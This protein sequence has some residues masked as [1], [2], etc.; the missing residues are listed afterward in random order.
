[1]TTTLDQAF[2]AFVAGVEELG[3]TARDFARLMGYAS[4][5]AGFRWTKRLEAAGLIERARQ[6]SGGGTYYRLTAQG[7]LHAQR[8]INAE[9]AS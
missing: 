7:R 4:S 2:E 6:A 5:D 9:R 3:P 8:V 1:M